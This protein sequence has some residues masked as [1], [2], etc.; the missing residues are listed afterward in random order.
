MIRDGDRNDAALTIF[1]N[2]GVLGEILSRIFDFRVV[3]DLFQMEFVD[4]PI[5]HGLTAENSNE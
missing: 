2:V 4:Q 1:G 5:L 3:V